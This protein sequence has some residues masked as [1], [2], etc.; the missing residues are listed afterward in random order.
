[1]PPHPRVRPSRMVRRREGTPRTAPSGRYPLVIPFAQTTMS[2]SRPNR[3]EANQSPQRPNPVIT[4]SATNRTPGVAADLP[5]GLEVPLGRWEHASRADH[6]LAEEGGDTIGPDVLDRRSQGVGV[7]PGHLDD[8]LDQGAVPECVGR[9]PR[10]RGPR[11]VHPVVGL[12]PADQDRAVRLAEELPV[13]TGHLGRGVDRVGS[14]AREEHLG[15]GNGGDRGHPVGELEGHRNHDVAEGGV[16]RQLRHLRR[17]RLADLAPAPADVAVPE[18]RGRIEVAASPRCPRRSSR[19]L[20]PGRA[21]HRTRR[22]PCPRTGASTSGSWRGRYQQ[23]KKPRGPSVAPTP[24]R[25]R[26]SAPASARPP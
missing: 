3:V 23:R 10:E 6:R 24:A 11:G 5:H 15:V 16:G 22:R 19:R 7:I 25:R 12:L 1:M 8:V 4:S 26:G 2:G 20:D 18:G 17:G 13:V 9:D 21:R 14:A